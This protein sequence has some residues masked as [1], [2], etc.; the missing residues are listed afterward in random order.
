M[1][2][3]AIINERRLKRGFDSCYFCEIDVA[4]ELTFVF[5]FKVE[6]LNLVSVDHHNAGLFRVGGIDKHFFSHNCLSTPKSEPSS[7]SAKECRFG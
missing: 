5:R 7:A 2:V 6:F 1:T 3:S 4:S